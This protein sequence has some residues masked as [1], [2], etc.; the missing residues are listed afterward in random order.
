M[1]EKRFNEI[2]QS[3]NANPLKAKRSLQDKRMSL[4][5]KT[6]VKAYLKY[7]VGK[8]DLAMK[9]LDKIQSELSDFVQAHYDLLYGLVSMNLEND[10]AAEALLEK[11]YGYFQRNHFNYFTFTC[12]SNLF[13]IQ[14]NQKKRSS[15]DETF[16]RLKMQPLDDQRSLAR[17]LILSFSYYS[18][19]ED[20]SNAQQALA[21]IESIKKTIPDADYAVHQIQ[22]FSYYVKKEDFEKCKGVLAVMKAQRSY[23]LPCNYI[24]MKKLLEHYC[25]GRAIYLRDEVFSESRQLF[26]E[27]KVIQA[28]EERNQEQA[29]F[30]WNKLK[31][32]YPFIY[33]KNFEYKGGKSLFSLCLDRYVKEKQLAVPAQ[34]LNSSMGQQEKLSILFQNYQKPYPQEFLC[35]ILWGI[36]Q[37]QKDDFIRLSRAIYRFKESNGLNIKAKKGCYHLLKGTQKAS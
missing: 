16:V 20:D 25:D 27:L 32:D 15:L 7:R 8:N 23:H 9:M 3:F 13:I 17:F 4:A 26:H 18:F 2:L 10:Q 31:A 24:Y 19:C 21:K 34:Y 5:E 37:P 14:L 6:I 33:A 30:Y 29:Q 12:L 28:F 36:E 22:M 11:A 1:E 35:R